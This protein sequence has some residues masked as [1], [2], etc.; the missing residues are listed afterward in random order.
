MW[1]K[2]ATHR[3]VQPDV[4]LGDVRA[5]N[6]SAIV[7]VGGW[8]S[9]A[10]QYSFPGHY[11]E[12]AYRPDA[13]VAEDVNRL[14]ED[15]LAQERTVAATCHGVSV[16]AWARVDGVSPLAGRTVV[17]PAGGS[18][19]FSFQ[20][21]EYADA[22]VPVR[23]HVEANGATMLVSGSVG[24]PLT[25]EDDVWVEGKIIT[26]ENYDSAAVFAKAIRDA[27]RAASRS[28]RR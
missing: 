1:P 22:A 17:A 24:D 23:W 8:G 26:A 27:V 18:P 10:Y 5:E 25:T 2:K 21:Q 4:A 3:P 28:S 6:Y 7:F 13:L 20:G 9:S 14:I 16:L 15:F 19:G 12:P 11:D